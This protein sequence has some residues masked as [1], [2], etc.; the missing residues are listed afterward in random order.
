MTM[1]LLSPVG[2][3]GLYLT[4]Y[5]KFVCCGEYQ[6][7][8]YCDAHFDKMGCQFCDFDPYTSCEEQH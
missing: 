7:T 8:Y 5:S 3:E 2:L 6:N 4:D 1:L